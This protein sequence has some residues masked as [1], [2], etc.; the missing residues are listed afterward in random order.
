MQC[1]IL[2]N[3]LSYSLLT[4][5]QCTVLENSISY[6][7]LTLMQC[8]VLENSISY[9]LLTLMQCT[10]LENSISYSLLTLAFVVDLVIIALFERYLFVQACIIAII[11]TFFWA[12]E[13]T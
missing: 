2:E 9:S 8:T 7:L 10:V 11:L 13:F 1:T 3:S 6:S 4:L 12:I 5:M